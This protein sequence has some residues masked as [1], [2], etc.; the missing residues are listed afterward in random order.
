M[1][2]AVTAALLAACTPTAEQE[3][4]GPP[5]SLGST[6]STPTPSSQP[7]TTTPPALS[8]AQ[9]ARR[10]LQIVKP[11]N[12]AMETL[13]KAINAGQPMSRLTRLAET[14]WKASK[15]ELRA[16]R[17]TRWPY[18]VRAPVKE[19]ANAISAGL[20]DWR[21]ATHAETREA[22]IQAVIAATK[23]GSDAAKT[24]RQRLQL[25]KYDEDDY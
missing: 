15:A 1:T 25:E 14:T 21:R 16:L 22:L 7:T 17:A 8:K 9:A 13:E 24:I 10:Y 5:K 4:V 19:L 23:H 12:V 6:A 20:S 11:Y 18:V 2:I 3:A